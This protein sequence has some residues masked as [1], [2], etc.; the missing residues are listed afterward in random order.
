MFPNFLGIGAQR[1]GTTWLHKNLK[2]HPE[3][4][5][6]FIKE[7]HYFDEKEICNSLPPFE[8]L[9]YNFRR[10]KRRW[11]LFNAS[12]KKKKRLRQFNPDFK[13]LLWYAKY[14]LNFRND[15][16]YASLFEPG[17]GKTLG[18]ITPEYGILSPDSV[19]DI[20]RLIPDA[21]I[22]FI[23]RNPMQRAWSHAL[24][25]L[26][27]QGKSIGSNSEAAFIQ[28]FDSEDSKRRGN[29]LKTLETWKTYYPEE[30]FMS[31]F[32]EEILNN[33]EAL[34]LRV[35][36][37][38]GVEA[39]KKHISKKNFV[40]FNETVNTGEIPKNLAIHLARLYHD[41]IE[42]LNRHIGGYTS[43]WLE[44]CNK[45]LESSS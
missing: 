44:N 21:K 32:F 22:I 31:I 25:V 20:Y 18:E 26:R 30:Q 27:D 23:M 28:H 5:M 45:L 10:Y 38:I 2:I 11:F 42:L 15:A 19:A 33:P 29:Y 9:S 40:K 3:I 8:Q 34:L 37:F 16:W 35:F 14:L 13:T 17:A 24:K 41:E 1:T 39:S 6:P 12:I 4:W 43:A 7:I 36:N